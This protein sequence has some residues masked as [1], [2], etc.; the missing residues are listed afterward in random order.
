MSQTTD[1]LLNLSAA[2]KDAIAIIRQRLADS[3]TE[4]QAKLDQAHTEIDGLKAQ[5]ND[6][7][8][9]L[10]EA[11]VVDGDVASAVTAA[12]NEFTAQLKDLV[13]VAQAST[14][15]TAPTVPDL[16]LD[17]ETTLI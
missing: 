6:A 13:A 9:K 12:T 1:A 14:P 15:P 7:L 10:A 16:P 3:A 4:N 2:L 5:L 17:D 8:Q 11:N